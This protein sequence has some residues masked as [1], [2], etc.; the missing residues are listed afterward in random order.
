MKSV[1]CS[2]IILFLVYDYKERI[3]HMMKDV[4]NARE[5]FDLDGKR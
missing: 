4:F 1:N 5:T 2:T 3:I